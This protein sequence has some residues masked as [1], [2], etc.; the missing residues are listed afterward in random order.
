[1][2][3]HR[4]IITYE[5]I[6]KWLIYISIPVIKNMLKADGYLTFALTLTFEQVFPH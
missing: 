1:M 2:L 5:E 4:G 3:R 6:H